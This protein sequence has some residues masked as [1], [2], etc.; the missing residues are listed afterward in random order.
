MNL[1]WWLWPYGVLCFV[2]GAGVGALFAIYW[3]DAL[4]RGGKVLF[5]VVMGL[6]AGALG[7]IV[8]VPR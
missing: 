5:S 4:T 8:Q 3:G 1:E 7:G 2:I 6:I